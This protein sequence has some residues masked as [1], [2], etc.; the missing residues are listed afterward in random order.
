M[1]GKLLKNQRHHLRISNLDAQ[2]VLEEVTQSLL[3]ES[4]FSSPISFLKGLQN[5]I[6][7]ESENVEAFTL[8]GL[9]S[10]VSESIAS[11]NSDV[12]REA[13]ILLWKLSS[14][15]PC[16]E[17]IKMHKDLIKAIQNLQGS[18]NPTV[19]LASTCVLGDL[20]G[21]KVS[22]TSILLPDQHVQA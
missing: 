2:T 9:L 13:I 20:L 6:A 18:D 3:A 16:T 19:A 5:V 10:T 11:T 17:E 1:E 21:R 22:G 4:T 7:A 12:Q 8:P 14:I 15:P